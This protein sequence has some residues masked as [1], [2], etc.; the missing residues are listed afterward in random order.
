MASY[1]IPPRLKSQDYSKGVITQDE[2]LRIAIANDANI[3]AARKAV[4]LGEAVQLTPI[5]SATPDQLLGDLGKQESDARTNLLKLGFRDTEIT[6]I[7]GPLLNE[8]DVLRALN[9]N[10]PAIEADVKRRFN[11]R[12]LTPTFFLN[13]LREYNETLN[14]SRGLDVNSSASI[15]R[16]INALINSVAE[17]RAI[18]PDPEVIGFIANAV[19]AQRAVGADTLDALQRIEEWLRYAGGLG[20]LPPAQQF[21][22]IQRVLDALQDLP[23]KTEI[24]GLFL[25]VQRGVNTNTGLI[26]QKIESIAAA[27]PKEPAPAFEEGRAVKRPRREMEREPAPTPAPIP[28]MPSRPTRVVTEEVSD[29]TG[30]TDTSQQSLASSVAIDT[31][32]LT[33]I[34]ETFKANPE[35]EGQLQAISNVGKYRIG[36]R[37]QPIN[38]AKKPP[39]NKPNQQRIFIDDTNI[40]DIFRTKFGRG[41]QATLPSVKPVGKAISSAVTSGLKKIKIGRGLAVKETPTYREFG[42]YAIH[43]PQLEQQDLLN[44]KYKSLGGIPKFKPIPVSDIFRDFLLDLLEGGKVNQRVYL[45]IEPKERKVFEEMAI[46]AGLWNS[47]GLKRTTTSTDEEDRKR[48]ELL[49]GEYIAGNNSPKVLQELRR[50][51]VKFINEGKIRKSEGMNLLIELSI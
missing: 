47:L 18:L 40:R 36:D 12:L 42:K 23:N 17:M 37:V 41:V 6:D 8:R 44:V 2:M 19:R 14:A 29:I 16:P 43:I 45:Q 46:G 51:V 39:A 48:F 24:Q 30:E 25:A 49:K 28:P 31:A 21:G 10:F 27:A 3:A 34:K 20:A 33:Q 7:I 11:P 5:Q 1:I 38:L 9:I 26:L 50:L 35:L 22:D 13:Y 32:T 4:K 15:R